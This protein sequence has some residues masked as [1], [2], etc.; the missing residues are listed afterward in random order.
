MND[1]P[2]LESALQPA[3]VVDLATTR[4]TSRDRADGGMGSDTSIAVV[5]SNSD[6]S[7]E[8]LCSFA[9]MISCTHLAIDAVQ[10]LISLTNTTDPAGRGFLTAFMFRMPRELGGFTVT[11]LRS[12]Q[13]GMSRIVPGASGA[14]FVGSWQG[15]VG[16]GGEWQGGGTPMAGVAPGDTGAWAFLVSGT[17]AAALTAERLMSGGAMPDPFAFVVRF[18]GVG[19]GDSDKAPALMPRAQVE[20]LAAIEEAVERLR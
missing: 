1:D 15:G 7:T 6:L 16:T 18:R 10:V 11:L 5:K 9:G 4:S 13:P 2:T 20:R 14:P 3:A 17:G 12:S 19:S 8:R